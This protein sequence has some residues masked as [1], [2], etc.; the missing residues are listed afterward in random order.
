MG[1]RRHRVRSAHRG[2]RRGV[3]PAASSGPVIA[4]RI[5]FSRESIERVS[6][7]RRDEAPGG[8]IIRP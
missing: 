2:A 4:Y 6:M 8:R 1:H 5:D 7:T 3:S